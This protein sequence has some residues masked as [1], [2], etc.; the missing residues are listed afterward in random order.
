M[1]FFLV[2]FSLFFKLENIEELLKKILKTKDRNKII[3]LFY[4]TSAFKIKSSIHV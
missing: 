1:N 3:S 2:Y 4:F